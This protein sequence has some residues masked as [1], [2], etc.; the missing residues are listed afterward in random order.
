MKET[1]ET[2][3]KTRGRKK[4]A[5]VNK[6]QEIRNLAREMID[7]GKRPR[8]TEIVEKLAEKGIEVSGPQVSTA[9]KG[10]GME[11][12]PK[13]L[14]DPRR[15]AKDVSVA[16]LEAVRELLRRTGSMEKALK[17]VAVYRS[18]LTE[19]DNP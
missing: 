3:K 6:A 1:T 2:P 13:T 4:G 8:P 7:N 5:T 16:D 18:L 14:P 12:R 17:A 10:T 19:A 11:Y 9:L 15:S